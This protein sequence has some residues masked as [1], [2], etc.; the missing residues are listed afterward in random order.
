MG[1]CEMIA[2][3]DLSNGKIYYSSITFVT[4]SWF[5][6]IK[7]SLGGQSDPGNPDGHA[8]GSSIIGSIHWKLWRGIISLLK[9]CS[10]LNKK[11][12]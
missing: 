6:K 2:P 12:K 4:L 9:Y 1:D 10:D 8:C 7:I 11:F 3:L 5:I